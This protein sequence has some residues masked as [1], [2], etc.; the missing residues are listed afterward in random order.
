MLKMFF[1]LLIAI[2]HVDSIY[3]Q[4]RIIK[5]LVI[6]ETYLAPII[7]AS[8]ILNDSINIGKTGKDGGFQFETTSPVFKLTVES[9]GMDDA[10]LEISEECNN[11]ELIMITSWVH[12]SVSLQEND[13]KN[14]PR[15]HKEAYEKGI[16]QSPEICY[17]R[18][19][20]K[21]SK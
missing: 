3:S 14:L 4:N 17:K 20:P 11:I 18:K 12:G 8:I 1:L 6:D 9:L 13:Y 21:F 2:S 16:F 19:Y 10:E 5:G 7:E 15:L